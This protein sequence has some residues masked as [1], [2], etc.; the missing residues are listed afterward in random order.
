M[1]NIYFRPRAGEITPPPH[2]VR[3]RELRL[4]IES[5]NNN[6]GFGQSIED[7]EE[8]ADEE[9]QQSIPTDPVSVQRSH[10]QRLNPFDR[11]RQPT[12]ALPPFSQGTTI[13]Q[14]QANLH[15]FACIFLQQGHDERE[16]LLQ[17]ERRREEERNEERR[18]REESRRL[19]EEERLEE[20][21]RREEDRRDFLRLVQ[22][23]LGLANTFWN[24]NGHNG[25]NP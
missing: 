21:R 15:M 7:G 2:V 22:A 17:I 24:Q 25:N 9:I 18:R 6:E 4:R 23:A 16:F 19:R 1:A 14:L 20:R 11:C 5:S 12:P 10:E 8:D 3:A 13:D